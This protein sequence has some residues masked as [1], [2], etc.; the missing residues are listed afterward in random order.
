MCSIPMGL[1]GV[2]A[3]ASPVTDRLHTQGPPL[4]QTTMSDKCM[5][6]PSGE[7]SVGDWRDTV[8]ET[9]VVVSNRQ[10]YRHEYEDGEIAVDRPGGGLV[11]ALDPVMQTLEGTWVAWGD[12]EADDAVTDDR[13]RVGVPPESP[14]YTLQRVSLERDLV[15]GYYDGYAN[16]SL[17]PLCHSVTG[18]MRFDRDHWQAYQ[19]ANDRFAAAAVEAT[20]PGSAVWIQDYH[21]ALAPRTIAE[22]T[23]GLVIQFWHVPWPAPDLFR[24]C[25]H[26]RDLLTGLLGNDLLGFHLEDYADHFLECVDRLLPEASVDR[27]GGTVEHDG[28]KTRVRA[29]PLGVDVDDLATRAAGTA[30]TA[31]AFRTRHDI[32]I[33]R[34]IVLGVDRLDYTKGIPERLAAL[35]RLW[36]RDPDRRGEFTYVQKGVPTRERVPAY[37]RHKRRIDGAIEQINE[38]FATGDWQPIV[39]ANEYLER[40]RLCGL[41]RDADVCLVT[42]VRDGMNL[43]AQEYVA[44][45]VDSDGVLVLSEFA[46]AS[47]QLGAHAVTVNPYATDDLADAICRAR[48]MSIQERRRRLAG[49]RGR[50][51]RLDVH[52]WLDDVLS[53]AATVHLERRQ[54]DV[55]TVA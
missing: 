41:Y 50:I 46:G 40:E 53:T 8:G 7:V 15:E 52:D 47:E 4:R 17:W 6:E 26:Y 16:Q 35:E 10:P 29:F 1:L 30:E 45:Q 3:I 44:C 27:F 42:P 34:P 23:D 48:Q 9:L 55:S 21:F 37:R 18:P 22:N 11:A 25:P 43:V 39:Q 32:P 12:G 49:L 33:D 14:A 54:G 20:D 36:E 31:T 28:T 13:N 24:V 2:P 5:P 38:R 19:K 51:D